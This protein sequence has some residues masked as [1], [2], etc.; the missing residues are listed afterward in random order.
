MKRS[1]DDTAP[2][3]VRRWDIYMTGAERQEVTVG[4]L[5]ADITIRQFIVTCIRTERR[6]DPT[7]WARGLQN[8]E[9]IERHLAAIA[10]KVPAVS[11]LDTVGAL[12]SLER[13]VRKMAKP[14]TAHEP[15]PASAPQ[16]NAS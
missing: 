7:D 16:G 5:K 15:Q 10:A 2:D 4:A 6:R 13:E 14:W 1:T 9:A 8:L 3:R 12:L 11:A